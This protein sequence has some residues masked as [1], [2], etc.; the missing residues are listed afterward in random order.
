MSIFEKEKDASTRLLY[1]K[2]EKDK[3]K[4]LASKNKA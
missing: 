4:I 1:L 2:S 3:E